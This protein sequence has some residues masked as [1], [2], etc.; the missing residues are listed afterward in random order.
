M[1]SLFYE[2][3]SADN[4]GG[5]Y[6]N[7]MCLTEFDTGYAMAVSLKNPFRLFGTKTVYEHALLHEYIYVL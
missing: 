1:L 4:S 3:G 5:T 7:P 6:K 2:V